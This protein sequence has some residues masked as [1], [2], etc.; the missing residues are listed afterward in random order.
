MR[1]QDLIVLGLLMEVP[2]H[3]YELNQK[4]RKKRKEEQTWSISGSPTSSR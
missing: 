1:V 3:S 2:K 4:V